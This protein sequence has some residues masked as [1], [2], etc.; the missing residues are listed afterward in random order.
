M[1]LYVATSCPGGSFFFTD[2]LAKRGA[3]VAD[4]TDR[5]LRG[6]FRETRRRHPFTI[7]AM[8]VL[9]NRLQTVWTLP[10][11]DA[12]FAARPRLIKSAFFAQPAGR[13]THFRQPRRQTR[14]RRLAAA[15][16]EAQHSPRE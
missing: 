2:N 12:Y 6:V 10:A 5:R 11:G 9:P 14:T 16:L 8:V 3:A 13:R 15:L 1:I 4:T 7:D